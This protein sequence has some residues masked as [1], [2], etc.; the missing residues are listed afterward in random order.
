MNRAFTAAVLAAAGAGA[1]GVVGCSTASSSTPSAF[2]TTQVTAQASSPAAPA[3]STPPAVITTHRP[4]TDPSNGNAT[5]TYTHAEAGGFEVVVQMSGTLQYPNAPATCYSVLNSELAKYDQGAGDTLP[6]SWTYQPG[7]TPAGVGGCNGTVG[8]VTVTVDVA[9]SGINDN[10]V[11][12][13]P[14]YQ[15]ADAD[16]SHDCGLILNPYA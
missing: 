14:N 3:S 12:S 9:G 8:Q 5:C 6:G 15:A 11:A 13:D 7:A 4:W 10:N 1:L 2:K 16:A